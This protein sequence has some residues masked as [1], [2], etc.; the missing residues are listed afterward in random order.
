MRINT[1]D[2]TKEERRHRE[3][4]R[5]HTQ[6]KLRDKIL[7]NLIV[8]GGGVIAAALVWAFVVLLFLLEV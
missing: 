1:S 3:A 5:K 2:L 6:M 4:A 7:E 8:V